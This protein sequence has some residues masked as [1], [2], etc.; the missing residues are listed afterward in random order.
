MKIRPLGSKVLLK[1]KE[2]PKFFK[3]TGILIPQTQ[4]SKEY[5]AYVVK[6]G[7]NV[8]NVKEGDLI[9]YAKHIQVIEMEHEGEDHFLIDEKD[10]HAIIEDD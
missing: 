3:G 9:K 6:M 5:M 4:H 7:K 2:A 10:I 8:A 1:E